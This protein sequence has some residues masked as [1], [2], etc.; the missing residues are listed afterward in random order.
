MGSAMLSGWREQGLAPSVAVDPAAAAAEWAGADLTV[1]PDVA[2]VPEAFAPAA[3]V[4]AVKPQNAAETLAALP[5]VRGQGGIPVD[6]GRANDRRH[7]GPA[8]R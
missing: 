7:A 8:R 5:A 1:V 2:A 3:V 4:F 6:H